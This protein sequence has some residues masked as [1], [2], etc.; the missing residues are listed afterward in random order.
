MARRKKFNE[1]QLEGSENNDE[2]FGL[3]EIE[4]Q[5]INR[6][7]PMQNDSVADNSYASQSN[8]GNEYRQEEVR[9]DY[10]Y[11]EEEDD[12]SPLPK[13]LG[14]LALLLL[15][16]AAYW[17]FGIYQPGKRDAERLVKQREDAQAIARR[18]S[19][20]RVEAEQARL[21]AEQRRADS[22]AN[23]ATTKGVVETLSERT[24]RYYV[25]I[26]S[27]IDSDLLMD[28]ANALSAKGV[29]CKIIPPFGKTKFSRLT[30][31]EGDTYQSTQATADG[32]KGEY[33]D[34]LWVVK[35]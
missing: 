35:Y 24:N 21:A 13:I 18:D 20:A 33:G 34:G 1:D 9:R 31:A 23:L 16:G 32:M 28:R 11:E 5:P 15:A 30:I 19:L 8:E 17:F 25:V 4:Y 7:E 27:A 22:L 26:A 3:P 12:N 6:E 29:N 14:V 2:T 10:T